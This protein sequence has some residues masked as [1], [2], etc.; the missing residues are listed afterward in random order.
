MKRTRLVVASVLV[1]GLGW[2]P[3]A[4]F[5]SAA[6][7]HGVP[8]YVFGP[9]QT[10][11]FQPVDST[12]VRLRLDGHEN[13]IVDSAGFSFPRSPS[14]DFVPLVAAP[15]R[16]TI[17]TAGVTAA[18]EHFELSIRRS[19]SLGFSLSSG[20]KTRENYPAS[21]LTIRIEP[22]DAAHVRLHLAGRENWIVDS[23]GFSL[24]P[25]VDFVRVV[26]AP[27]RNAVAAAGAARMAETF[28]LS[29]TPSG[30]L[31]FQSTNSPPG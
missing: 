24:V 11:R 30:S 2:P 31:R 20:P 12:H 3:K 23:T 8:A 5:V 29:I 6:A 17:T 1:I 4:A 16:N 22:V 27:G 26:A 18:R 19:G 13:W 10:I 14:P 9:A 25:D 7:Q 28:E 15:G 21:D